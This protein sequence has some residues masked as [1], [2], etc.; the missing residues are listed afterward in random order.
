MADEGYTCPVCEGQSD[1]AYAEANWREVDGKLCCCAYCAAIQG[2]AD[3]EE[4]QE[5]RASQTEGSQDELRRQRVE[6]AR[7]ILEAEGEL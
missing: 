5:A 2:G 1:A 7:A 4:A 6:Q 3:E